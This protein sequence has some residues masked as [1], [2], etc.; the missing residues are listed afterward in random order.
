MKVWN[1]RVNDIGG[2]DNYSFIQ[3]DE[4]SNKQLEAIRKIYQNSGRYIPED[5]EDIY[6]E[7]KGSFDNEKIPTY[8]QLIDDLKIKYG[9]VGK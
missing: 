2:F 5:M 8:K 6:V 7:I 1:I 4:P 9:K 3:E